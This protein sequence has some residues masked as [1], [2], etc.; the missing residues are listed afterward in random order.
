MTQPGMECASVEE[1]AAYCR[2]QENTGD[3]YQGQSSPDQRTD[4][5]VWD[6]TSTR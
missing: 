2:L 1:Y 6:P 3:E 5:S 4:C